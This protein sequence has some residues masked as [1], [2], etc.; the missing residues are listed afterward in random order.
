M[1]KLFVSYGI[2]KLLKEKGF[3]EECFGW[4]WLNQSEIIQYSRC[5]AKHCVDV[6]APLYQQAFDWFREKHMLG[7]EC[8][9]PD[10]KSGKWH[11]GIHKIYGIGDYMNAGGYDTYEEAQIAGLEKLIEM[12]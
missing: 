9:T 2:A 3:N 11:P 7:F 8:Q 12:I 4:Y 10:G 5:S 1:K 6:P